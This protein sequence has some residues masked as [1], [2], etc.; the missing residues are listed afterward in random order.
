MRRLWPQTLA[1]QLVLLLLVAL[2]VAQ[3]TSFVIFRDERRVAFVARGREQVID[4][5]IT[6]VHLLR[7]T[8]AELHPRIVR[9]AS[10]GVLSFDIAARSPIED[11]AAHRDNPLARMLAQALDGAGVGTVLVDIDRP[12]PHPA[13]A[14]RESEH[15][16]GLEA[17]EDDDGHHPSRKRLER[18]G[19][20]LA[21]AVELTQGRW[22][23]ARAGPVPPPP[24]WQLSYLIA[25]ALTAALVSL[26]A[27]W[28]VRRLT[29]PLSDLAQAA[30]DFGRGLGGPV[31]EE[32]GPVEIRRTVR[33]FNLMRERLRRFVDDRTRMLAAIGHDLRTP[34][35]S[36]RLRAEFVEDDE[37][38][39]K[40]I[41]TLEEM[42]RMVEAAL[43]F[44]R[45]EAANEPAA[46]VDLAALVESVVLDYADLGHPVGFAGGDAIRL[47]CRPDALRRALRNLIENA[48]RYGTRAQVRLE[49][50]PSEV[51]IL[52]EDEGPG[53]PPEMLERV[54]EPF[55]RVEESRSRETGGI[56]L[57]LAIA[58]TIA[59]SHGGDVRLS[60]RPAGGLCAMIVL[61][62]DSRTGQTRP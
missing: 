19:L 58:R 23:V 8:P 59:R 3:F 46:E 22:L 12:M 32:R 10:G 53:I 15:R 52:V 57:G 35:T 2:L 55:V 14:R 45:E 5:T 54:F 41:E 50:A 13:K 4:R 26:A 37:T 7:E 49:Q 36:L 61:P 33:A 6:L 27:V 24:G 18:A 47:R 42:Q 60:N 1:G 48:L 25:F 17:E 38:R 40:I 30:D 43:G 34:L 39:Q 9:A 62:R 16:R 11:T 44:L 20:A 56:G 51:R 21:V 29:R 31:L 28:A